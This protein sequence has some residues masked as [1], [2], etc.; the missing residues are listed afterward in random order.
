MN[1]QELKS[2]LSS[3]LL[4]FPVT[5]FNAQGDFHR[6]GYIKRLEW[7]APYGATALFAAGGTGEFFSLA[8]S[9]YSEIIKTA[10]DTCATSVPILAG[11]GGSTRQA[12]EYAQEA[13][14]LGAKGLLLLPH[15]LTEASQDGVAAHVE[16]VC[17]SVKIGVVVYNRNVC[18]LTAPLLERLAERCPNLIGYKDGLGDIELMVSIRR[19]LG[20]RFSY[21]GGLPTAEV[22]AAAYKALGVPVYSSAVFNFIPKTAMDFYHAIARDDH[23]T[24]GKI[25]DDFF[26]PYLDIRNRKAGY[27][28]SIVKAGAKI[29]GYDAGPVRAPLTDLTR[30]RVRNARRADRQARRAV[31]PDQTKAAEQS[32]AFCVRTSVRGMSVADSK[33]FDNYIN[34][35]WV[36][37]GDYS[38]NINPS[39]LTDAIGDYAKADLA[40]VHAAID[41]ARAAF[42]AWSTSGIQ[43]RHDSLDKVGTEILARREELGTL[44]AREE[45]K[46]LPEAIG[47]VTRAGN[48]FKFFAGE[49]LRL[50]GD[51]LPSV[52]PGVNVEVT[53]EALGVVGLITPWNFPIAIPA[54]KIAPA[55]AYGNC[56]VLKPADL[57][58][59]CAWA[60]AEII[61]RA[62]FP[63]GV[64]NLVMGS[65][66][67]VGD[68]LVQS[69]KVDGISFTGSVGVGRQIA[70]SCVSR[71]AKVQLEMGGKNPQIILDDADLKQAVEL[72]VQSAFYSTGQRCTASSRFIVTAGIHDQ[73]VE[74]MAE[75]MQSIKVGH[76]LK[77]GTDIG[78]VVSQAQLEQDLK[79]IDIGQS[80]GAR[81]VSGGGLVTCD[82]EGYYLAPTLFA[83]S[84]ASMRISREEIFGPVA[85][86]VRV[87]DYEAALAMA[88]DTEFGLSAG[89]ATTSLKYANHFKR[90][91]QA[92]M[93][94]VNLPTAGVDYHVPFGG[95]KGSSYGSRE[96]GRYAQEFYTVVKTSLHRLINAITR[97][98]RAC[99]RWS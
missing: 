58:P 34:G 14:R 39:E 1:P 8:A 16:A 36:A 43:A 62:G 61:S 87:A 27:A 99:S 31:T 9:E 95:R 80:E 64:F 25:I 76:A 40:Q 81:L 92:G 33:R 83:D 74:A 70:V 68:A 72:S 44:L 71:Q 69:P 41:A 91:S 30:R 6:A 35:E 60:L 85:N 50:S 73:F 11:V 49:C 93:V 96:Q 89:I 66:R 78:P 21:L 38:T 90:H 79:Y 15:Y 57:V 55:L 5:D 29:A 84:E 52:R 82:T 51:Y 88:N 20:D 2:I 13:E 17:K 4:S 46:T 53:R 19:R 7:L 54:W 94:M 63:A 77:A 48:I 37:G 67:V 97:R 28:V 3:G 32:A 23:A 75:R 65:G 98:S 86:V 47:E 45:G 10:V 56:V 22:Y 42:P 12:I 18:R 26:L 59:G 24:V